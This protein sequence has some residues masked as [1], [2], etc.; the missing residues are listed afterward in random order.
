MINYALRTIL[1]SLHNLL[2]NPQNDA[3]E[4]LSS[5]FLFTIYKHIRKLRLK[6]TKRELVSGES[7]H[8]ARDVWLPNYTVAPTFSD[9][10]YT[11]NT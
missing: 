1:G 7:W 6:G 4:V 2:F 9:Q 3:E 10:K 11:G 8:E 5:P